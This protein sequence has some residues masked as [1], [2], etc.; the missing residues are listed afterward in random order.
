MGKA[1]RRKAEDPLQA[2]DRVYARIPKIN[3]TGQ[4]Q[5]TCNL[6][7]CTEREKARL[8]KRLGRPF[9][10]VNN[11]P[12]RIHCTALTAEGK[13][14]AYTIRPLICRL[15]GVID[16]SRMRCHHGCK[17]E[18][19]LTESEITALFRDVARI[20]GPNVYPDP[21]RFLGPFRQIME[22]LQPHLQR[23]MSKKPEPGPVLVEPNP[24]GEHE[25]LLSH[26]RTRR[27]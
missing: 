24:D 9:E 19:Y 23:L 25:R 6:I 15:Y 26:L 22:V 3:C 20:G 21:Q 10:P 18:R 7:P 27:M 11:P 2:L 1:S 16:D 13:C 12:K 8:E 14:E 17:P 4:C 5:D